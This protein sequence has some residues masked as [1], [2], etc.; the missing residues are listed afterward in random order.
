MSDGAYAE[1]WIFRAKDVRNFWS[2][3]H[4]DRPGGVRNAS[5]TE[6][7][8]QS[9]PIW[10]VELGCP[11]VDKGAN[12][13]N[14]FIDDKSSESA[15]PPFSTGARDDLIQRR[16]L[17]AYLSY[18]DE[19]GGNNS[20][21]SLYGGPMLDPAGVFVWTWD[22]RPFPAYPARADVWGDGVSWRLG[23]WLTGR[24]GL[25]TLAEVVAEICARAGVDDVDAAALSGAVSGYVVDAPSTPRAAL[26]P[27]MAAFDF[28]AVE[29]GGR[30]KFAHRRSAESVALTLD[31]F[32]ADSVGDAFAGRGDPA[33]T[34]IEARLSFLDSSRDY[35]IGAVSARRLDNAAGGVEMIDAPLVLES[36]GAEVIVMRVLA[37]RRA[38]AETARIGVGP[39]QFA[40]EPGDLVSIA[41]A[42]TAA[43]EITRIEDA[44]ARV[45]S[46]R[47]VAE[48]GAGLLGAAE[49]SAPADP[50]FAP[51]PAFSILDLPP[52]PGAEDDERP[53]AAVFAAPW[54]GV[55]DIYLG[56]S[57]ALLSK[58]G[59][60]PQPAIMGELA[61]DLPAGPVGRWDEAARLRVRLYGGALASVSEAETLDGANAFA[62][63]S[64][65]GEWEILQAREAVL[66][67]PDTYELTHLLR[68]QQGSEQAM[69]APAPAGARFVKLDAKLARLSV[70]GSEWG[71]S[72]LALV[73]EAG[74]AA[75]DPR[76]AEASV[77]LPHAAARPFAPAHLRAVR[78]EGGDV[79]ISWI[80]RARIGGDP[81]GP[82]EP[83]L[84][85]A[86]ERYLLEILALDTIVRSAE[87]DTSA[88]LYGAADQIA[89]FGALPSTLRVRAAELDRSGV[90]GLKTDLT[91]TL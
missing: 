13:P 89:D 24:A 83:P 30:L 27:L 20:I 68:G 25:A 62:V 57:D 33:A 66:T 42:P 64:Q 82:G 9:K 34:P 43:F 36:D 35:L 79:Q 54:L 7:I 80:R 32:T 87:P 14:L 58:R 21:S 61:D 85:A 31:D 53:L 59:A 40:L 37:E 41:A 10:F 45:L 88:F 63:E 91:M 15:L 44:E 4:Y 81:W 49:P 46:L 78:G 22:A 74:G 55:H 19:A 72:A 56:A 50:A 47:R 84:E 5:P 75:A 39:A 29:S 71:E 90:A 70:G 16:A 48:A 28:D 23:H 60:A 73:P 1:P 11:A 76:V 86:G 18:W 67:A 12:A 17:E 69:R 8:A 65:A 38:N 51:T 26:E 52:L 6:W 77:F 3:A 2:R